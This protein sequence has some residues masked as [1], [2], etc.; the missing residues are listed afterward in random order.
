MI[1]K[2]LTARQKWAELTIVLHIPPNFTI[3]SSIL[4]IKLDF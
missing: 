3:F 2:K 4:K 1:Q